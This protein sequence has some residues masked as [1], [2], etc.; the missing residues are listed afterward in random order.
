MN[1]YAARTCP[2]QPAFL[3]EEKEKEMG[4][5]EGH[6]GEGGSASAANNH[7]MGCPCRSCLYSGLMVMGSNAAD[8]RSRCPYNKRLALKT[9]ESIDR[10]I[11]ILG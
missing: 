7:D 1:G 4:I 9:I 6:I 5:A 11:G 10:L 8:Y 2:V 3:L